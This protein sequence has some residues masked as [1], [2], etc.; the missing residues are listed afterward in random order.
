[1]AAGKDDG[2]KTIAEN[3]KARFEYHIE[4]TYETGIE[5]TGTEVK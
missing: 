5:L 3:R 1:M 4:D 2:R